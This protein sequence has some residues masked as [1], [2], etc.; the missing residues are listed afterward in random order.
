MQSNYKLW[1]T[2]QNLVN[3]TMCEEKYML[4]CDI[5]WEWSS[6][7]TFFR[8]IW[9]C[10]PLAVL[11]S[12]CQI[13]TNLG[14]NNLL[15]DHQHICWGNCTECEYTPGVVVFCHVSCSI[16]LFIEVLLTVLNSK[17]AQ[18][19]VWAILWNHESASSLTDYVLRCWEFVRLLPFME[20]LPSKSLS[21]WGPRSHM[22]HF[23]KSCKMLLFLQIHLHVK[24]WKVHHIGTKV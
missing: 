17:P 23:I 15:T 13:S 7:Y 9:L 10:M 19:P 16:S 14:S 2:G 22:A 18:V 20:E 3:R 8:C 24:K 4:H 11:C 12:T 5:C 1:H 6:G 21:V